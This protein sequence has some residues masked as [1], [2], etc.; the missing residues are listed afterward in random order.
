MPVAF[1]AADTKPMASYVRAWPA[2]RLFSLGGF[3]L[4]VASLASAVRG[5]AILA[6]LID[7]A[8]DGQRTERQGLPMRFISV[9]GIP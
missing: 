7:A 9:R 8:H 6:R 3:A 2:A 5:R 4:V 1:R